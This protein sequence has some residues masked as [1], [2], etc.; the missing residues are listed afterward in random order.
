MSDINPGSIAT[1]QF[2][3]TTTVTQI[4][5]GVPGRKSAIIMA[6]ADGQDVYIGPPDVTI[7]TGALI[8]GTKG[9]GLVVDGGGAIYGI[10][11]A[12]TQSVSL[13]ESF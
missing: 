3:I 6:L 2:S 5:P 9:A 10:V 11:A 12:G 7:S 1:N 13:L 4:S 8:P